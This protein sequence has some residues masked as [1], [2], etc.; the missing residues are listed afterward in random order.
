MFLKMLKDKLKRRFLAVVMIA[1]LVALSAF[2]LSYHPDPTFVSDPDLLA[3]ECEAFWKMEGPQHKG[4][5]FQNMVARIMQYQVSGRRRFLSAD[6][7]TLAG[8]PDLIASDAQVIQ[9]MYLYDLGGGPNKAFVMFN[10]D[11]DNNLTVV[12][13][14]MATKQ[15]IKE[16]DDASAATRLSK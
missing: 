4:Q 16:V 14:N 1:I 5:L 2:T 8:K 10:F 15:L 12:G 9:Y 7:Q 13:T 3:G 11:L 6:I